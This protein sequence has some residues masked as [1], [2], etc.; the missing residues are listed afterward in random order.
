MYTIVK[1]QGLSNLRV[2]IFV[3]GEN[4]ALR[5]K[6]LL[7]LGTHTPAPNTQRRDNVYAWNAGLTQNRII[8]NGAILRTYFYTA[9]Q[10][11]DPL[12]GKVEV[13][14]KQMGIG[15]PRVFKKIAG[16]PSKRVDITL[17]TDMLLH[18]MRNNFDIAVLASGD[19]DY[20]P[21]VEAVQS[22]GK[23][24]HVWAMPNGLGRRLVHAADE[25]VDLS[26]GILMQ[27]TEAQSVE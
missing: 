24:V 11:D 23:G 17:A 10:G 20:V 21:L 3:D 9:V 4:I 8:G 18:A 19:D 12:L 6:A 14:L 7:D 27:P 16:R 25:F 13:E 5:C 2:M 22:E 26:N 1:N 15:A